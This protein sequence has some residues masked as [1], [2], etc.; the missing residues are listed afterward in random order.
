MTVAASTWTI[1]HGL[2]SENVI[3]Q[4]FDDAKFVIIPNSIQIVD[5][6]TVEV[7]FNSPITGVARVVFLD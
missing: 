5:D 7:T 6:D 3:V 4:I 1:V 2:S